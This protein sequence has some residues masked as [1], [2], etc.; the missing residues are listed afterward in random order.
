MN[1]IKLLLK[2]REVR[3]CRKSVNCFYNLAKYFY[4][5]QTKEPKS[6]R[7]LTLN[8]SYSFTFTQII[9]ESQEER[10]LN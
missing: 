10:P 8:N 7:I 6:V 5:I 2:K 1:I 3:I 4:A 9:L